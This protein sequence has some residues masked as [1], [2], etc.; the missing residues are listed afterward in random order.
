MSNPI[1][2]ILQGCLFDRTHTL[3][4]SHSLSLGNFFLVKDGPGQMKL[5]LVAEERSR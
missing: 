1:K 4:L 3:P 2:H 5:T